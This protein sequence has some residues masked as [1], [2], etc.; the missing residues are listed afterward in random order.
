MGRGYWLPPQHDELVAFDGFFIDGKAVYTGEPN[1]DWEKFLDSLFKKLN[2]QEKNLQKVCNWKS[3]GMGQ[4]YFVLAY[5]RQVEI[6]VE[7]ADGYIAVY[8]IIPDDCEAPGFAKRSFPKYVTLIFK[9]LTE[10]Y[11]GTISK[12]LNSRKLT[13]VG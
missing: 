2:F 9:T 12:R 11:P 10:M 13:L 7:D 4:N 8:A 3:C 6:I 5:N 1:A